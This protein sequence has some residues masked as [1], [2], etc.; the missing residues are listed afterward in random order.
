M[1]MIVRSVRFGDLQVS[2]DQVFVFPDGLVG[3]EHLRHFVLVAEEKRPQV[4]WLQ[5][6]A[7]P[8]LAFAAISPRAVAEQYRLRVARG[9]LAPLGRLSGQPLH[10]LALL[11]AHDGQLW[12]NLKAP[13]VIDQPHAVGC[14]VISLDD[15]PVSYPVASL[16]AEAYRRS[17]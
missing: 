17:A 16:P 9:Q 6:L 3:F 10:V 1:P 15:W 4:I 11:S 12:A 13:I 7:D 5:A 2:G 14:Q 8:G